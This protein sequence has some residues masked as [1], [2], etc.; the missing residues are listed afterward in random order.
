MRVWS[1][2]AVVGAVDHTEADQRVV[3][4][5][6][7]DGVGGLAHLAIHGQH[8]GQVAL[9]A[10]AA[11]GLGLDPGGVLLLE[12]VVR[13]EARVA[14]GGHHQLLPG[15]AVQLHGGGVEGHHGGSDRGR[16]GSGGRGGGGLG[17]CEYIL[18]GRAVQGVVAVAGVQSLHC[19]LVAHEGRRG[20][21]NLLL[22]VWGVVVTVLQ[23]GAEDVVDGA[24]QEVV[25]IVAAVRVVAALLGGNSS[26]SAVVYKRVESTS[27]KCTGLLTNRTQHGAESGLHSGG[28]GL[29]RL[30]QR[31]HGHGHVGGLR[32]LVRS[33]S[34]G[35][36]RALLALL[37]SCTDRGGSSNRG[38]GGHRDSSLLLEQFHLS[39][40]KFLLL[41]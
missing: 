20:G 12:G 3:H 14:L 29:V 37:L 41:Q 32:G 26:N 2:V 10:P 30:V 15:Q 8:A 24:E 9:R 21:R 7:G 22:L 23:A 13:V 17:G 36:N 33:R 34:R 38:G 27:T 35:S 18:L 25:L 16:G 5:D 11:E 40:H 1:Y 19:L 6:A 4:L 28:S 31:N 39:F